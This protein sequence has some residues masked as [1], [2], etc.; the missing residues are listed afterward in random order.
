MAFTYIHD[1]YPFLGIYLILSINGIK[2]YLTVR[3]EL[4]KS[5]LN[6]LLIISTFYLDL[7]AQELGTQGADSTAFDLY[8]YM[9]SMYQVQSNSGNLSPN[10]S[11]IQQLTSASPS[12]ISSISSQSSSSNS[13]SYLNSAFA[14]SNNSKNYSHAANTQTFQ[15]K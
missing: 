1:K 14:N 3:Y 9:K 12:S 8:M 7:L 4:V 11:L 5:M 10:Q 6:F 2:P 15:S 13:A